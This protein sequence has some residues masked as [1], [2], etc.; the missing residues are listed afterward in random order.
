MRTETEDRDRDAIYRLQ[1]AGIGPGSKRGLAWRLRYVDR[2]P[3]EQVSQ[4]S[5]VKLAHVRVYASQVNARLRAAGLLPRWAEEDDRDEVFLDDEGPDEGPDEEEGDP[6]LLLACF[7]L[8]C[9]ANRQAGSGG[10]CAFAATCTPVVSPWEMREILCGYD[11]YWLPV[12]P[13]NGNNRDWRKH[14]S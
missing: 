1:E 4:E 7:F 2:I 14:V 10:G 3:D 9:I 11:P 12:V 8:A 13:R 5:G 6:L